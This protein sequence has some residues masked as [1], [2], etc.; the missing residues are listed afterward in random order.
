MQ[1]IKAV[2]IISLFVVLGL[3]FFRCFKKSEEVT[4]K[5]MTFFKKCDKPCVTER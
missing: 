5:K 4:T 1:I 2:T 3:D